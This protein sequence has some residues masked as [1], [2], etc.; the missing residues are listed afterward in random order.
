[1]PPPTYLCPASFLRP[2]PNHQV[3]R[4]LFWLLPRPTCWSNAQILAFGFRHT[5]RLLVPPQLFRRVNPWIVL[6]G[7]A[8]AP[9]CLVVTALTSP[10]PVDEAVAWGLRWYPVLD[11]AGNLAYPVGA[12]RR[13]APHTLP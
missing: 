10:G 5:V 6:V 1:M 11:V 12:R 9:V 4:G 7:R 8:L 13:H 3:Y 2:A